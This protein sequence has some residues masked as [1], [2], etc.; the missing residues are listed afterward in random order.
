MRFNS[1]FG[2]TIA[3]C[4]VHNHTSDGI[5]LM[6]RTMTAY[7]FFAGGPDPAGNRLD[8]T[9]TDASLSQLETGKSTASIFPVVAGCH[10]AC[11]GE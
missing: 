7:W 10:P 9:P 8:A 2:L 11:A 3:N 6:P 5:E 4:V 1:G